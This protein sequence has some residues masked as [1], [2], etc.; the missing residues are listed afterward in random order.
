[1]KIDNAR[2]RR[3]ASWRGWTIVG[4]ADDDE[5]PLVFAYIPDDGIAV[6]TKHPDFDDQL[7]TYQ[8]KV[9]NIDSYRTGI[10]AIAD[11]LKLGKYKRGH[12]DC[13][14]SMGDKKHNYC[15]ECHLTTMHDDYSY[16]PSCGVV[17]IAKQPPV[18]CP[19]C[20]QGH[21]PSDIYCPYCGNRA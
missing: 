10:V 19:H 16:C 4:G 8:L 20:G 17:L 3:E 7:I 18:V 13:E 21:S 6:L 11:G 1:M 9:K 14:V 5:F 2:L 12:I 15:P